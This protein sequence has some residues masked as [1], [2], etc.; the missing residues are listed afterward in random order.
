MPN[1]MPM[2]SVSYAPKENPTVLEGDPVGTASGDEWEIS[3]SDITVDDKLG[4]GAFGE[5]YRGSLKG[6]LINNK[7]KP[8]FRNSLFLPVAIKLLK[9]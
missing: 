1:Y 6:P 2:S 5:V 3:P 7:V 9:G 8:E 4:E